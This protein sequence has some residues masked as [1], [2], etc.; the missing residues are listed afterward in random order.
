MHD[1]PT[2]QHI[3]VLRCTVH[4]LASERDPIEENSS[5][6]DEIMH[7]ANISIVLARLL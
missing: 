2:K 4:V 1:S 7:P 5:L 6:K 3:V